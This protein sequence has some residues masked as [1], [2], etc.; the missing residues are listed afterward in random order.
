MSGSGEHR[1]QDPADGLHGIA[2]YIFADATDRLAHTN[3]LSTDIRNSA[4]PTAADI[5]AV[6]RQNDN[7]TFHVLVSVGPITYKDITA[8]AGGGGQTDTVTG[9]TGI[10]N[11]GTNV[12]AVL[13]PTYGTAANTI[14]EGDHTHPAGDIVSGTFADARISQSSVTQHEGALN[15]TESQISDL[16]HVDP[17]AIHDNVAGEIG[18]VALKATPVSGDLLLIEDSAAAGVKKRITVGSLPTGGGGEANTASNVNV[19]GVGVFKQKAGVDL[20]FR[21]VNAGSNK[22]SVA[23]DAG[24]NEIDVDINE[25]NLSIGNMGGVLASDAAHGTR[26]GGTQHAVATT[27]VAGFMSGA[28]K[29]KL[30]GVATGATNTPLSNTAPVNVTKAAAAAGAASEAARQDHKHDIT[31]AAAVAATAGQSNAEGSATSLA[32]SDHTHAHAVAA[33][34]SVS[35]SAN[36]AGAAAT[37][38]R[39][40]HK[41]DITTGA[42]SSLATASNVEGTATTLARSDHTHRLTALA[43]A[44]NASSQNITS[45]K[46]PTLVVV[47]LGSMTGAVNLN[48]ANGV[49]YTG[50]LTGNVTLSITA[51]PGPCRWT[52]QMT[53]DATGNRTVTLPAGVYTR[54][55]LQPSLSN[56]ALRRTVW[57]GVYD[58]STHTV[59]A[60]DSF[61]AIP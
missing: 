56:Q 12:N 4:A 52:L 24:N 15:I 33:P 23:L 11:T 59:A 5:G 57:T 60:V 31:T 34:V 46:V 35:K 44:L 7:D 9:A 39:S 20:E 41:H 2:R 37:F 38:S 51:P 48:L 18:A 45:I 19:G 3:E 30:D 6:A 42:P 16:S 53:Q 61:Q 8:G 21:G 49:Y 36:A 10:T 50:T 55:G 58:G 25:N 40:D 26:G 47:A 43:E 29:T 22:I 13:E 14:A 27:S 54:N 1:D 17:N 32:R 28:D